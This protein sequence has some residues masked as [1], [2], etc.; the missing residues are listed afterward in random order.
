MKRAGSILVV[1]AGA[2]A[3]SA[4]P[5]IL[6]TNDFNRPMDVAFMCLGGFDTGGGTLQVSGRPMRHCH[7][8]A[9]VDPKPEATKRTF[10]FMPNAASGDL[11]VIDADKWKIV[12]LS[13]NSS[14]YGRV[15]L[16]TLPE[17]ISVSDDGCRL[18]SA[19]RG[20]CDMTVVD[21]STLLA[22]RRCWPRRTRSCSCP[23]T[24]RGSR[25]M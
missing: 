6:P 9:M 24:R 19:N 11:S 16:G 7:P 10:A 5:N 14:G 23:P 12:D 17:Q 25:M 20:S 1:A 2:L 13:L 18:V 4:T 22:Q 21:P 8:S 15:P 3:C